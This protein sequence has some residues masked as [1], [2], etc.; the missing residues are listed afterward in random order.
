MTDAT[1]LRAALEAHLGRAL[2]RPVWVEG[3][4]LIAGGASQETW[5]LELCADEGAHAGALPLI[6]R[7]P[8]GGAIY[9]SS[10]DLAAEHLVHAAAYGSRAP[11]PRPF[12]FF[13]D[14][15]GAP[16]VLVERLEAE[17]IGRRLVRD[18]RFARARAALPAQM[19]AALAAIHRVDLDRH[20]LW[21]HLPAPA[22]GQ[23]PAAARLDQVERELDAIGEPHPALELCLRWLR[24]HEPPPPERLVLVHGDFRVGNLL[25]S[26]QAGLEAVIDWEFAHIGDYAE[27]L[28]WGLIREWRFGADE[29]RLGGVGQPDA[30]F[31]AYAEHSGRQVDPA[32]VAYWELLGNVWWAI[33][34]L[35]QA[36]RH[37]RG[38]ELNLEF[39][40]LGRRAAEMEHEALRLLAAADQRRRPAA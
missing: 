23:T 24:R 25:V 3:L 26:P 1:T 40:S 18:P 4:A 17:S 9:A 15:L 35:N 33:G 14:L 2:G 8:L 32:R 27:D 39:A 5:R 37:L 13:D 31:S 36:R 19:G 22:P 7:R 6:L 11:V 30:F 21:A 20:E 28:T 10:L 16:A 29:L 34:C 12:Y 38:E